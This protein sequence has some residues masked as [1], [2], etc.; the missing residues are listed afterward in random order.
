MAALRTFVH[1]AVVNQSKIKK[2]KGLYLLEAFFCFQQQSS[3]GR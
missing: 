1:T 3:L 2:Q